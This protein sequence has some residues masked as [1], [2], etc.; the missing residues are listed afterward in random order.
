MECLC[1]LRIRIVAA[2][3]QPCGENEAFATGF[4][5]ILDDDLPRGGKRIVAQM[6]QSRL[7]IF[8][9]R[10]GVPAK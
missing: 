2:A 6:T 9:G 4:S 7:M 5:K 3:G 1:H 10:R 8:P